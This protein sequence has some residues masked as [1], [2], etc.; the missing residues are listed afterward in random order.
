MG[1]TAVVLAAGRGV[2]MGGTEHKSLVPIGDRQPLMYYL[3]NGLERIG[4]ES[5]L[6]VTGFSPAEIQSY[7]SEKWSGKVSFVRNARYASWG[8]FHS[9]RVAVDQA[10][11]DDLLVINS[12]V[13]LP[14]EPLQRVLESPGDLVLAV[15]PRRSLD[16]EDMRV[17][18][19]KNLVK[20][21]GK[22]MSR[23]HSQGEFCGVS[24]LR[25]RAKRVYAD[26]ATEAEWTGQTSIYYE[27]VFG[28]MLESVE[29]RAAFVTEG[30]YAEVDTPSDVEHAARVIERHE[31]RWAPRPSVEVEK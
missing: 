13:V 15:E 1:L 22:D 5:L 23:A 28:R 9:L 8:N 2:R 16:D 17:W 21:I 6:V 14:P 27:D 11:A 31:Q 18:L 20:G 29:A 12:D 4:L 7:V 3:L 26:V 10:P 25:A 19:A 30:E 24:L